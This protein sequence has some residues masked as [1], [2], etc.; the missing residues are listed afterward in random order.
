MKKRMIYMLLAIVVF[1]VAI[2]FVKFH[3]IQTAIAAYASFAPPPEAVTTVVAARNEWPVT[4]NAIGT[5][6]AAQGV[7]VSA[8][9][10]GTVASIEFESGKRVQAGD[11]LVRLDSRQEQAQLA[12]AKA[13]QHLTSVN[14]ERLRTL[15]AQGVAAAA[16]FD[17]AEAEAMQAE[18]RV[19]EIRATIERKTIRAPFSG[20]LG[21][22]QVN[23]G[24]YLNPGQAVVPLQSRHPVYVDFSVPQQEIN[25]LHVGNKLSVKVEGDTNAAATGKITAV[26][27]VIDQATRNVNVR[28]TFE[29][30][31]E[32]LVPGMFVEASVSVGENRPVIALPS[33][34]ISHAPYGDFVFIVENLKGKDS[35]TT[36]R[37]V[38]QQLVRL[39]SSRGDQVAIAQGV[40]PGQEVVTSGVFKLRSGAAVAVRNDVQP[41]NSP[42]PEPEDN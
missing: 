15:R 25:N 4:L 35:T 38:R 12:A 40:Q 24:Q 11:V 34:S 9:L 3:Q 32:R 21:I 26:N 14:L 36:Y 28:A 29:N 2:G 10:P 16:E 8:D 31:D 30:S 1:T 39:G 27:S 6:T 41:E 7:V 20:V 18:A 33:S 5:V 42:T 22:R 19:N 37:G 23:L 13:Q 17:Q